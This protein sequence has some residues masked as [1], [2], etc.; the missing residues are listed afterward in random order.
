V[1]CYCYCYYYYYCYLVPLVLVYHEVELIYHA[2][3]RRDILVGGTNVVDRTGAC[4][5]GISVWRPSCDTCYVFS[6]CNYRC[7]VRWYI[8]VINTL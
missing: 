7:A 1:F 3:E 8:A 2:A 6:N 5:Y 4:G